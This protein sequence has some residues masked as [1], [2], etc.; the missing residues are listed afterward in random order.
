MPIQVAHVVP[1]A[2]RI[3]GYERQALLLAT[4][5]ARAG[6]GVSIITHSDHAL[7]LKG[8]TGDAAL[9]AVP[10]RLGRA[11]LRAIDRALSGVRL[12]HVHAIDPFSAAVVE[13]ARSRG[14]AALVKV[15][16]QG[17]ALHFAD[18]QANPPEVAARRA[19]EPWRLR[20][21]QRMMKSAW[22][23]IRAAEMFIALSAAI[24]DELRS[25]GIEPQ[26][27]MRLP[28]AVRVPEAPAAIRPAAVRAIYIGRLEERKRIGDLLAAL[29]I[30]RAAHGEA[31]LHIVG[32]GSMRA[33]LEAAGS[34][35]VF[36]GPV[37]DGACLLHS[38]DLFLF[39]SER[40]GCP[41]ALLEA[42]AAGAPCIATRIPGVIDWFDDSMMALVPP[43]Q[44]DEIA[45]AWLG[46]WSNRARR[47]TMADAARE[48]VR[49][50]ASV[51]VLGETYARLY[52]TVAAG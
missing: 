10:W 23:I 40:E 22:S 27:I 3:G 8:R 9:R 1:M 19:F 45:R 24:E 32:D 34:S 35:A 38:S 4:H 41:N 52:E 21:Q 37:G 36:H 28:N 12:L 20:R 11:S 48:H 26:R 5:Q 47:A 16:T 2:T 44:P 33:A 15:A 7:Q 49:A 17:D 25:V 30:V 42:A 43:G 31:E 46:L 51:D 29:E 6:A 50:V 13:R 14:I 18:P 39:P